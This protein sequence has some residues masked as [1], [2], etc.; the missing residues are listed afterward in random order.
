[1][2]RQFDPAT[3]EL[4][5]RPQPVTPELESDLRNLRQLNRY[6]GSYALIEHFLRR[7][8]PPGAQLRV[9]DLATGSGDIPR[10]VIDHARKV[11]AT[12]TVD[13][14]D[15][16]ESTL[17]IARA[18]SAN[19]PEIDFKTGDVLSFG[20]SRGAVSPRHDVVGFAIPTRRHS[21][22]SGWR[23]LRHRALLPR[24]APFRR[25]CRGPVAQTLPGI[26][27]P[28]CSRLRSAARPP[29]HDR[30]LSTHRLH[31]SRFHDAHR[32]AAL[33]R[34]R[35]FLPRI[36]LARRA[37]RLEELWSSQ[38]PFRPSSHLARL[39]PSSDLSSNSG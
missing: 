18:L 25:R 3:P 26:V 34:P 13:A 2:K 24:A 6:F 33:R 19:Y 5:D 11:S 35:L 38:I 28:L 9:L 31:L 4:M 16:Q 27:A 21:A 17:K 30:R 10:L 32:R 36:P 15:Q 7:W 39:V 8:I 29:R 14:I 37:R 12:V 20:C 22:A 23:N 1:M